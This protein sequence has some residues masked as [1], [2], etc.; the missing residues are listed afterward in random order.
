MAHA[1]LVFAQLGITVRDV[2]R[3]TVVAF[4]TSDLHLDTSPLWRGTISGQLYVVVNSDRTNLTDAA[5]L[6]VMTGKF[7]GTI[8]VTDPV[9]ITITN[10][11]F[12]PTGS[13]GVDDEN[14]WLGFRICEAP[15]RGKFRQPFEVDRGAVSKEDS[16]DLVWVLGRALSTPPW[17]LRSRSSTTNAGGE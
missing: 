9:I 1:E 6:V 14:D 16:G 3:C 11:T 4:G 15:F 17:A 2:S 13:I 5:E 8:E 10:G 7:P 12:K